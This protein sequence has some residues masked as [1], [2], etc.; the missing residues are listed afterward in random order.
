MQSESSTVPTPPVGAIQAGVVADLMG[1]SMAG[2]RLAVKN[3]APGGARLQPGSPVGW[4]VV[5]AVLLE[6]GFVKKAAGGA[7]EGVA[8]FDFESFMA[9]ALNG[10][11]PAAG[12]VQPEPAEKPAVVVE[13]VVEPVVAALV[14]QC[15]NPLF[16][17]AKVMAAGQA[18]MVTVKEPMAQKRA[19]F[20]PGL[21]VRVWPLAFPTDH[22]TTVQPK[23]VA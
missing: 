3:A 10:G 5:E 22:F 12:V 16:W 7:L 14:A 11:V 13:P 4:P 8:G 1:I 23:G 21:T 18:R 15:P 20:R 17:R 9:Q 2:L 19:R 6:L